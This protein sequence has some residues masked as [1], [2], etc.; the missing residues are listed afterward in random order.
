MRM[1]RWMRGVTK[2]DKIRGERIRGTTKVKE[3]AKK[4]QESRFMWYGHV[5]R[6][7]EYN[8]GR[9][10]MAM[11]V[12][13]RRKGGRPKRRWLDKVKDDIKDCRLMVCMTGLHGGVCHRTSTP[14]KRWKS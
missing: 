11:K 5:M 9:S 10:A 13:G 12:Q 14:Y 4:V 8:I 2:M 6:R 3:I 7:E 1:L